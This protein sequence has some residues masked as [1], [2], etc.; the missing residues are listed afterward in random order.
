MRTPDVEW[1]HA[2]FDGQE[3]PWPVLNPTVASRLLAHIDQLEA[4]VEMLRAAEQ[5]CSMQINVRPT[6]HEIA[7]QI[8]AEWVRITGRPSDELLA[9][10]A[11]RAAEALV[12]EGQKR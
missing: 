9:A 3:Y 8:F 4:E 12:A 7:A 5:E 2:L 10:S 11:Y 1:L 6:V